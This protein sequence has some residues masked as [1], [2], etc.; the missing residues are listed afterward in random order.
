MGGVRG[1]GGRLR[2]EEEMCVIWSGKTCAGYNTRPT[3]AKINAMLH[4]IFRKH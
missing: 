1:G 3:V 2:M 4:P